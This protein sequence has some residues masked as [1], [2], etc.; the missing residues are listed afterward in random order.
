MPLARLHDFRALECRIRGAEET[1]GKLRSGARQPF[2][3]RAVKPAET[4]D[5]TVE[6]QDGHL[7]PEAAQQV[8]IAVDVENLDG[9]TFDA[10]IALQLLVHGIAEVAVHPADE[11]ECRNGA[12]P[13][14]CRAAAPSAPLAGCTE[15]A[16]SSTVAAGTSPTAVIW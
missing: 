13:A 2:D 16:I 8:R 5:F 1:V 10:E 3:F 15:A 6:H 9:R 14:H 4:Y 11:G 7:V 12:A